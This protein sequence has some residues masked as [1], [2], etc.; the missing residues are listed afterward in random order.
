M[1]VAKEDKHIIYLS[2][3]IAA[4]IAMIYFGYGSEPKPGAAIEIRY[5]DDDLLFREAVNAKNPKICT[6]LS[7][8]EKIKECLSLTA[9]VPV[10]ENLEGD[11]ALKRAINERN[12]NYC[13]QIKDSTQQKSCW[14]LFK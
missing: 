8:S 10:E 13:S 14:S 11:L 3:V 1:G 6:H 4:V 12:P 5:S 9:K 7:A 2:L